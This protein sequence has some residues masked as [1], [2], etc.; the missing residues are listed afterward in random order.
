MVGQLYGRTRQDRKPFDPPAQVGH[1]AGVRVRKTLAAALMLLA[2][3]MAPG[4]AWVGQHLAEVLVHGH[5]HH[6]GTPD[7]EHSL[8]LDAPRGAQAP[9]AVL[10]EVRTDQAGSLPGTSFAWQPPRPAGPSPP[11]LQLLCTLLI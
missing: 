11:I 3:A 6:E 1:N 10:L 9:A 5:E 2:I 8:R 4:F 7:H